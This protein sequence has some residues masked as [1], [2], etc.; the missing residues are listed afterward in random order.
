MNGRSDSGAAETT[1]P[2]ANRRGFARRVLTLGA[3]AIVALTVLAACGPE[4]DKPYSTTSPASPTAD[5]IHSLYKL[6]FWLSLV[7]FVGVQFAIVYTA[8]RF[9]RTRNASRRPAQIHGNTRLEITWTVI[10]A[11]ILLVILIPT[12]TTIFS[13]ADAAAE[14]DLTIEVN[15]K[16]WWWEVVYG[17]DERGDNLGVVTANEIPV[18]VGKE[19]IFKLKSNN[20][21]HSFWVPRLSGKMDLIPG[22]ENEISITAEEPGV[23]MGECAEFCG[24]QHAWMRFKIVAMPEDQF[25]GWVN[26]MRTGN[27]GTTNPDAQLP[28][29][30]A[31]APES[32]NV[33]LACHQVNGFEGGA[34]LT[35]MEAP[36]TFG[37][38][39]TNLACRDTIAAGM[40]I[41]N[42]ENL[43]Q[44]IH[45]PASVKP[46]NYM[47]TQIRPGMFD[48][49]QLD[50]LVDYLMT[51]K[52]AGGCED[53]LS[54][55]ATPGATPGAA[56]TPSASP[57]ASPVATPAN[58]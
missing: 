37:P 35:G 44:W 16:Q 31:R 34:A 20:V 11:V 58:D 22:H 41:N 8:M 6:V 9:R 24:T 38:S 46:G 50:E 3:L 7:V 47:A 49:Q 23:Y 56:G 43:R 32:F 21:I 51:L 14:G 53:F 18:P 13:H 15:G 5:D 33:C 54:A 19:V 30:V 28:E 17:E 52:P 29:G 2:T 1:P 26:S 40:L 36:R 25:Y 27:P 42:E 12:I 45:D 4:V 57:I 48:D 39:L 55:A 10:P